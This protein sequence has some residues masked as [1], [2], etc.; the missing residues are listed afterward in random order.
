MEEPEM[1]EEGALGTEDAYLSLRCNILYYPDLGLMR[2]GLCQTPTLLRTGVK[3]H[4]RR[5]HGEKLS[6]SDADRII[7]RFFQPN[8]RYFVP[9]RMLLQPIP[10]LPV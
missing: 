7:T 4:M 9:T 1:V 2:C 5:I 3:N 6:D 8:N 10:F